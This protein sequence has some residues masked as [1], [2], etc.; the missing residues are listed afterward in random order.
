MCSWAT[1][2]IK[3]PVRW[4]AQR[5]EAYLT[6][7]HGRDHIT[8]AEMAMSKDGKILGL[9]VKTIANLG[10]Y[11]STFAPAV[12]TFLYGTLLNGVYDMGAINCEVTGVFTNTTAVDA[13]RGAG[14][15]EACYVHRADDR[16][17]RGRPQ[18]GPRRAAAEELHP[19]VLG[20]VP[21]PGGGRRTTAGTTRTA[22]D[23]LLADVRLQEVPGRAGGGADQGHAYS[24]SASRRTSRRAP[25]RRPRWWA[26]SA[27]RPGSTSPAR[28]ACTRREG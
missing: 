5:R 14:R 12:P 13:Y 24:A 21:D 23:R 1:R 27:P 26:R 16:R 20:R 18:D 3:R 17:R 9:H 11:L 19:E 15:P 6:D 8:D 7:A 22:L 2:Q 28:C 25:S 4:T 10:A